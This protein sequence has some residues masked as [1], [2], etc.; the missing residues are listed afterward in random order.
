ML[1]ALCKMCST[2]RVPAINDV[3]FSSIEAVLGDCST[4]IDGGDCDAL[5]TRGRWDDDSTERVMGPKRSKSAYMVP[6]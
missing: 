6:M 3:A 2:L 4:K 1:S 5:S